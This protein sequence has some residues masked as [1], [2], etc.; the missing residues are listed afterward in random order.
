M[1]P[2]KLRSYGSRKIITDRMEG[3]YQS[4]SPE[5]ISKRSYPTDSKGKVDEWAAMI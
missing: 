4:P 3:T 5:Q 2:L 1:D